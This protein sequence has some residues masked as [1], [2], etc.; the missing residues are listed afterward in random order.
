MYAHMMQGERREGLVPGQVGLPGLV[1]TQS[2]TAQVRHDGCEG[3]ELN[4][5]HENAGK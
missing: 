1:T 5:E 4:E 3:V 2:V